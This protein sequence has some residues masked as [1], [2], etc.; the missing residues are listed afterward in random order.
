LELTEN[1]YLLLICPLR[2]DGAGKVDADARLRT[3]IAQIVV[4]DGGT[5]RPAERVFKEE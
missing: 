5:G 2:N 3:F 4:M 1:R